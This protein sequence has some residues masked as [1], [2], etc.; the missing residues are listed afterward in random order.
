MSTKIQSRRATAAQ[1]TSVNP[2][3][4]QG[5][6]GVEVDTN[7]FKIGDG[8]NTWDN[9]GYFKDG[10]YALGLVNTE[11]G[12]R[13]ANDIAE[14]ALRAAGDSAEATARANADTAEEAARIAADTAEAT[15]RAAA[16]TTLT[17]TKVSTTDTTIV[18]VNRTKYLEAYASLT[19]AVAAIG[20][21][22]TELRITTATSVA[23]SV[24]VP[25]TTTLS[26]EGDG[27]LTVA[28]GQTLTVN[29]M[30]NPG[31]RQV[32]AGTGTVVFGKGAVEKVD[33][34]WFTGLGTNVDVSDAVDKLLNNTFTTN[35]GG[36]LF[37]PEG[38]WISNGNHVVPTGTTIEGCGAFNGEL[39]VSGNTS[40]TLQSGSR[41]LFQIGEDTSNV[42]FRNIKL[43]GNSLASSYGVLCEGEYPNSSGGLKF[44]NC[45]FNYFTTAFRLNSLPS[46]ISQWQFA[47][48]FF[49][50]CSFSS[51]S[52]SAIRCNTVD[53]GF[54]FENCIM[55]VQDNGY[56][57]YF[58]NC[59]TFTALNCEFA[60]LSG[61]AAC[62]GGIPG[63]TMAE[64]VVF[65]NGQHLPLNFIGCQDEGFRYF[66]YND[67]ADFYSSF[68]L[69]GCL[70]Q[71]I[72]FLNESTTVNSINCNYRS[73]SIM[74]AAGTA[75]RIIS[76]NDYVQDTDLC[77]N[78]VTPPQLTDFAGDS[79]VVTEMN[80]IDDQMTFRMPA[81]F[82]SPKIY[83][84][85]PTT[86]VLSAGHYTGV[87]EDKKLLRLGRT[88]V[89]GV[90]DF[91]YDFTREYA[92][93][94]LLIEGNQSYP[95][96]GF[97]FNSDVYAEGAFRNLPYQ[98]TDGVTITIDSL[99]SN[100]FYVTLGGNRTLTVGALSADDQTKSDGQIITVELIQDATGSRTVTL[101]SAFIFGTDITSI[102]ATTTAT[103]RDILTA[104][105]NKRADK[106]LV[107]DFK[108]GFA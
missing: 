13:A 67:A 66:I 75:S 29:S 92:T 19:A 70:V 97:D 50:N 16:D 34:S 4:A 38:K 107:L 61:S 62:S 104:Q 57:F 47:E 23:A 87:T 6:I 24:T 20:S 37:F 25:V 99:L 35:A 28:S 93:G 60:G 98:L 86:P 5:E 12:I 63:A 55:G 73:K 56:V 106:W 8:D 81:R 65:T 31:S 84:G 42:T 88:D 91:Y 49:S 89:D 32:F 96:K 102:T 14:A 43:D 52:H 39:S 79:I 7:Q 82:L 51:N 59:G 48:I 105:Y 41:P 22:P 40:L 101:G 54:L 83:D 95:F 108:K 33:V 69:S 58:E 27:K 103:K 76:I 26:F 71:S 90:F 30:K 85:D 68:N 3:L 80:P 74:D 78:T 72:I 17:N 94:R 15:A 2:I 9:L 1:W 100:H 36:T 46:F 44:E 45:V 11:A 18:S 77:G 53:T 64:A 21:T 10:D